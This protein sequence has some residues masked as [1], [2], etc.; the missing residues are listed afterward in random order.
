VR[1]QDSIGSFCSK[2]KAS[3]MSDEEREPGVR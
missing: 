1:G 3:Q 2:Q